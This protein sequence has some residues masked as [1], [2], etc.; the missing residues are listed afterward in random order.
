MANHLPLQVLR[1]ALRLL[2]LV[3][4]L[5]SSGGCGLLFGGSSPDKVNIQLRKDKQGLQDQVA[6]LQQQVQADQAEIKGLRERSPALPTLP[7]DRLGR[8][9]TTHGLKLG[10][11][12]GGWDKDG[13]SP[14]DEGLK[15]YAAPT[16][17]DGQPLKAAGTFSVEAFDLADK[18]APAVGRWA[19]DLPAAKGAWRGVLMSYEYVLECPW[20]QAVPRRPELTLKVT[21][22]DELT[23]TPYSA[24]QVVTV[25]P[26]PATRP[27][28]T[29]PVALGAPE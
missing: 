15:V 28:G 26:P 6:K 9:F 4:V 5:T 27:A 17:Q 12:T 10:R 25:N 14:G 18:D 23:Q 29:R 3:A 16:D 20:Q 8:L 2:P 7:P 1:P 24:Q 21:F 13:R 11:L 19:F 22:V